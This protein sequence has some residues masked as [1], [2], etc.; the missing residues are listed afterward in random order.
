MFGNGG[1]DAR[2]AESGLAYAIG[3][4]IR[5]PQFLERAAAA[6]DQPRGMTVTWT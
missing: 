5:F 2:S 6:M 4:G 3:P 1:T